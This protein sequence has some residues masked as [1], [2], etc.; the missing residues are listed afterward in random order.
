MQKDIFFQTMAKTN[1]KLELEMQR[2]VTFT[3]PN[4]LED[5]VCF[6]V[7]WSN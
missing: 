4:R 2:S 7:E 1:Q 5:K 3:I 6:S